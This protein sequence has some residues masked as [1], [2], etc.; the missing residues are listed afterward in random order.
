[1]LQEM[2]MMAKD[3]E[4]MKEAQVSTHDGAV[5]RRYGCTAFV[6]S[7]RSFGVLTRRSISTTL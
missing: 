4:V 3:P 2:M 6:G 1:M 5:L 7:T